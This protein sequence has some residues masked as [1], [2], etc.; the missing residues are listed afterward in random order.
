MATAEDYEKS[1]DNTE[2]SIS[3]FE[4][5]IQKGNELFQKFLDKNAELDDGFN[6]QQ[7]EGGKKSNDMW[8]AISRL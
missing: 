4:K 7:E 1:F 6:A 8:D 2:L 3:D 5:N